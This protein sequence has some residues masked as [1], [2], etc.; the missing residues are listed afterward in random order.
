MPPLQLAEAPQRFINYLPFVVLML[1]TPGLSA[2]RRMLG[3]ILGVF[4]IF[5]CHV[6][7]VFVAFK[8]YSASRSMA[9]AFP[10]TFPSLLVSD[11]LPFILWAIIA[12][13]FVRDVMSRV[14]AKVAVKTPPDS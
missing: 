14:I 13:E 7:M 11:A 3:T 8:A 4:L 12:H 9:E 10:T 5:L 2:R 6:M 1:I